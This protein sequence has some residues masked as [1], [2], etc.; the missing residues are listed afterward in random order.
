MR[1]LRA[2]T[3]PSHLF[4]WNVSSVSKR[5]G[6]VSLLLRLIVLVYVQVCVG[7]ACFPQ[8]AEDGQT[9]ECD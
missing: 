8:R 4:L 9:A 2:W 6:N 1:A 5:D 3:P 7:A